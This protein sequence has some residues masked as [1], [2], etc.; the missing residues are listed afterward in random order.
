MVNKSKNKLRNLSNYDALLRTV[1]QCIDI[2]G[3]LEADPASLWHFP[4]FLWQVVLMWLTG[5]GCAG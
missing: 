3:Q 2:A 1:W 4:A 5:C